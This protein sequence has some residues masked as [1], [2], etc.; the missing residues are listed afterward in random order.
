MGVRPGPV[1]A[2]RV[3]ASLPGTAAPDYTDAFEV[4]TGV[5]AA[6]SPEQWARAVFEDAPPPVRWFLLVGWRGVLGL[7][8]G[9]RPSAD[10][11]L[12]WRI[13]ASEPG[14]V[15]LTVRSALMT[16]QLRLREAGSTVVLTSTVTYTRRGAR[17]LWALVGPVHRRMVPYL[18]ARAASRR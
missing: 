10:H 8:L 9:P 1:R 13:A 17:P 18:L 4:T 6:R 11:V 7:R 2:R 5:G 12:G 14:S 16:A 3:A 15:L